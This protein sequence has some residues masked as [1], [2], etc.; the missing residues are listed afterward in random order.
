VLALGLRAGLRHRTAAIWTYVA[1]AAASIPFAFVAGYIAQDRFAHSAAAES[2]ARH[3]DPVMMF[4]LVRAQLVGVDALLPGLGGALVL[5]CLISTYAYGATL[6]VVSR[7][8]PARTSD[9]FSAGGRAFG[10]LLRLLA[11]GMSFVILATGLV[12][13]G[14][15]KMSVLITE[16]WVSEKG[17]LVFRL[18]ATAIGL[19]VFVWASGA[20]DFMR[21]EAVARGEHRARYAFVRGVARAVRHP[22]AVLVVELPFALG[23][24]LLTVLASLVD[25]H[26]ARSSWFMIILVFLFQQLVAFARALIKVSLAGAEVAYVLLSGR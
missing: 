10:R 2:F 17:V 8:D 25:V 23:A 22:I 4:E 15:Y 9:F 14:L 11:F 24:V 12:T 16:D 18:G 19:L 1:V 6:S 13:W 7:V 5:W 21:V 20:Y 26:V 3:L